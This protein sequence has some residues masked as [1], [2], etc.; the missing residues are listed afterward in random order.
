MV[1]LKSFI[2]NRKTDLQRPSV[3]SYFQVTFY[4]GY[5]NFLKIAKIGITTISHLR[6]EDAAVFSALALTDLVHT[7]DFDGDN[8]GQEGSN[9]E[10]VWGGLKNDH[11]N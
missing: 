9:K 1:S 5:M 3:N 6:V 2:S 8:A 11:S 10:Q 7:L 4:P